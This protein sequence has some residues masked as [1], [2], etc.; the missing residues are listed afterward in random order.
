MSSRILSV[1]A[2]HS[3][4]SQS[5]HS[6]WEIPIDLSFSVALL[7]SPFFQDQ[8]GSKIIDD[9]EK[10]RRAFEAGR[11]DYTGQDRFQHIQ[12]YLDSRLD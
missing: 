3:Q 11:I 7:Y 6:E 4:A 5:C 2:K 10:H 1:T 12:E 9:Q 8:G